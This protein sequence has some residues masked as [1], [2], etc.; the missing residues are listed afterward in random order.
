LLAIHRHLGRSKGPVFITEEGNQSSTAEMNDL[1]VELMTEIFDEN[2]DLFEVDIRTTHDI[3]E[4]YNVFRSF[5]RGSESRAVAQKVS[6]A[7]RYIVHRWRKKESAGQNKTSHPIDQMY[8][9]I[10]LV[11]DSFM[12]YTQAM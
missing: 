12:R 11:K 10:S 5:R 4:K 2:R 7:D 6:E 8:V 9:D 3:S 1:F